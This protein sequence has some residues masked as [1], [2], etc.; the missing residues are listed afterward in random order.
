MVGK[1]KTINIYLYRKPVK[2]KVQKK[3]NKAKND[4]DRNKR[5]RSTRWKDLRL[6]VGDDR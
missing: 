3:A 5:Q 6:V 1:F 4:K 2:K